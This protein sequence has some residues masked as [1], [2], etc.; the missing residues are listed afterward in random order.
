MERYY[1]HIRDNKHRD[2]SFIN[3]I[4]NRIMAITLAQS[5]ARRRHCSLY[6]YKQYYDYIITPHCPQGGAMIT[7]K[8][9]GKVLA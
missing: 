6:I 2:F 9:S 7:I 8:R 1:K 3:P 4:P 5:Q